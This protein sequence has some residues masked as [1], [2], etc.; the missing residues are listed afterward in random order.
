V[1]SARFNRVTFGVPVEAFDV[2]AY[3]AITERLPIVTEFI[4]KVV[5]VCGTLTV[6]SLREFFGFSD[7][8][9][10]SVVEAM[11][12]QGLLVLEGDSVRLS[13]YASER[14]QDDGKPPSFSVI[15]KKRDKVTFDLLTYFP[16]PGSI[17]PMPTDSIIKLDAPD[18]SIGSSVELARAAYREHY[19]EIAFRREEMREKSHG[20]YSIEDIESRRRSYFTV[21]VNLTLDADGQVRRIFDDQFESIVPPALVNAVAEQV[22]RRMPSTLKLTSAALKEFIATFDAKFLEPYVRDK[23]FDLARFAMDVREDGV[24][25]TPKG[26][27][28]IFGNLY[29]PENLDGVLNRIKRRLEGKRKK[30]PLVAPVVWLAAD[31]FLWGR[32]DGM[33]TAV[34]RL[35]DL[36]CQEQFGM[37]LYMCAHADGEMRER[38]V[39]EHFR[40]PKLKELHFIR[41]RPSGGVS[42]DGRVEVLLM[43]AGFVYLMFHYTVPAGDGAWV[44][45]GFVST[46]PKHLKAARQ[47]LRREMEGVG[48]GGRARF[49]QKDDRKQLRDLGEAMPFLFEAPV[50][51]DEAAASDDDDDD[52]PESAVVQQEAPP[53]QAR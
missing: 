17:G 28:L 35:S 50:V 39:K 49:S 44:P 38:E 15:E 53:D 23:A 24:V 16:L 2:S 31:H 43:P 8:E 20:V 51:E 4:L 18:K 5:H 10:V 36:L 48:Y 25:K 40:V 26:V 42:M 11:S 6:T 21:N 47:F 41:P 45:V 27:K 14:F 52:Q 37:S 19:E 33:A 34:G 9:M 3:V 46:L 22:A 7:V 32:G 13:Q 12:N 30:G 1:I 29:L